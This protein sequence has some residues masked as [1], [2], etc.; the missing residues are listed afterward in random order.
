MKPVSGNAVPADLA[1]ELLTWAVP[2]F[3]LLCHGT[4][5]EQ[6]GGCRECSPGQGAGA[7]AHRCGQGG[8]GVHNRYLM[9][10]DLETLLYFLCA[11]L[12]FTIKL[13]SS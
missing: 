9:M 11:G 13:Y 2:W 1:S 5:D 6:S 8:G 10:P 3:I 4:H 12:V 7:Y